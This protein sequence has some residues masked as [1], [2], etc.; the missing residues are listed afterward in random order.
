MSSYQ[1]S[2]SR[3]EAL[4][5]AIVLRRAQDPAAQQVDTFVVFSGTTDANTPDNQRGGSL[6]QHL[7][8]VAAYPQDVA[9]CIQLT[10][11]GDGVQMT[12]LTHAAQVTF[13]TTMRS[14][15]TVAVH[16]GAASETAITEV[17]KT[18]VSGSTKTA[19]GVPAKE[20]AI[21]AGSFAEAVRGA[22]AATTTSA[23]LTQ[24]DMGPFLGSL[25]FEKDPATLLSI[26]KASGLCVGVVR[27]FAKPQLESAIAKKTAGLTLDGFE[28]MVVHK[29]EHPNEMEGMAG[30]D[31]SEFSMSL[32]PRVMH[33]GAYESS[34][35]KRDTASTNIVA[36]QPNV[37]TIR[38]GTKFRGQC[39]L[40]SRT[41]LVDGEAPAH[42]ADTYAALL[43][44]H[45]KVVEQLSAAAQH[46]LRNPTA[47]PQRL[48]DVY[49]NV[50][51]FAQSTHP[52]LVPYLSKS[53]GYLTGL[54]ICEPR[55]TINEKSTTA[56]PLRTAFVVRVF[57]EGV[58]APSSVAK[59][60]D[61]D[62][63]SSISNQSLVAM[64]IADTVLI[65]S[66]GVAEF[67][68]KLN[69]E[70]QDIRYAPADDDAEGDEAAE[71]DVPTRNLRAITRS[72]QGV[73]PDVSK[74]QRREEGL[75]QLY[76][77]KHQEWV[78]NGRKSEGAIDVDAI[79]TQTIGQ[80]A[81]GDISPYGDRLIAPSD[82]GP[83]MLHVHVEKKVAW[84]PIAGVATPF[85]IATIA[86]L[87]SVKEGNLTRLT[88]V[89]HS[90]QEG[91]LA[92]KQNRTKVFVR[93][94]SYVSTNEA[95]F[96]E[97][98]RQVLA[99][100]AAIKQADVDRKQNQGLAKQAGLKTVGSPSRLPNV[101]IR[102]PPVAGKHGVSGNL[103][104]HSNGLR[105]S[106]IATAP[107]DILF[108]NVKH[109]IFQPSVNSLST[110]FHVTL[111][112]PILV[113]KKKTDEISFYADVME[114][115]EAVDGASRRMDHDREL[116]KD[117]EEERRVH[118]TNREFA[119]FSRA[120]EGASQRQVNTPLSKFSFDGVPHRA[121]TKISG[122]KNVV[123][124][125]ADLP[126]FTLSLDDVEL[127]AFERVL[128]SG[129][130]FD[131][132]FIL[133][134]HDKPPVSIDNIPM[135]CL[136]DIKDWALQARLYFTEFRANLQW[137]KLLKE[138]RAD[139]DWEP[140]GE[141]GFCHLN[142]DAEDTDEES[143]ED[144]D[145]ES[146]HESSDEEDDDDSDE[147]DSD[148]DFDF[149]EES[150][151]G[152]DDDDDDDSD[153][154]D[155]SDVSWDELERRAE[156]ADQKRRLSDDESDDS[157]RAKK[158]KRVDP[159]VGRGG[160]AG[161]GRGVGRRGGAAAPGGRG[162]GGAAAPPRAPV[163]KFAA[164]KSSA[165]AA[166]LPRV[167]M[168]GSAPP[169]RRF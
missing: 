126:P 121:M 135:S 134:N 119:I 63:A 157:G 90:T 14:N 88:V 118:D 36:L 159:A 37:V 59:A 92:F 12:F 78:A 122:S 84:M 95:N 60:E 137:V 57:V 110:Y 44:I 72:G 68:T 1:L 143:E 42:A 153:K 50:L 29:I 112:L 150:D 128:H 11:N 38:V 13:P 156:R 91:N 30:I 47:A 136:D 80:L 66:E 115:S 18:V 103:E 39:G 93:D 106:S 55:G 169:P 34:L 147:D 96:V 26:E 35:T 40:V 45:K 164:T 53:F 111:K 76:R 19:I 133:K 158:K 144:T 165:P 149:D 15:V 82:L 25:L 162:F 49:Q 132:K 97:F 75:R 69:R 21:Q 139:K 23:S 140:Y 70:L 61:D 87:E 51:A 79:R 43:A 151:V 7:L 114:A 89:F 117:Q 123:W 28:A 4:A 160:G 109:F 81:L 107:V 100:Q 131:L 32:V 74:A 108:S 168:K 127:L 73:I 167:G 54:L 31:F 83:N 105:F 94:V 129:A 24:V 16:V 27:R 138:S 99:V 20:V 98:S 10:S 86:R 161:V 146:Y 65:T 125:L 154:S 64:E 71:E 148:S 102:P 116:E 163:G 22:L 101:K 142:G 5:D 41:Y 130:N 85:H 17:L 120:V 6:L 77:E 141:G 62:G 48:C 152:S 46:N 104:V 3:C 58:P 67:R 56:V 113:G 9:L 124:A 8:D 166:P 2:A 145:D 155:D 33:Q 52:N